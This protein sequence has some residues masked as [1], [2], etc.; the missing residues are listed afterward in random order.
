[1][2]IRQTAATTAAAALVAAAA[3]AAAATQRQCEDTSVHG[4]QID[5]SDGPGVCAGVDG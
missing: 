2:E 4:A 5:T 1:M 3:A